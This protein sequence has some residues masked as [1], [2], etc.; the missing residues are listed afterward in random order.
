MGAPVPVPL[1]VVVENSG[2]V[3]GELAQ[4]LTQLQTTGVAAL[5]GAK[6]L[7]PSSSSYFLVLSQPLKS[8]KKGPVTQYNGSHLISYRLI[9][10][11]VYS[12]TN[13]KSKTISYAFPYILLRFTIRIM[14]YPA[15]YRRKIEQFWCSPAYFFQSSTYPGF[16][17]VVTQ[18]AHK[19]IMEH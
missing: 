6:S 3:S 4:L 19:K 7:K 14:S 13:L 18:Q 12:P 5:T 9:E 15:Y 2:V 10:Y 16:T 11:P 17:G 1:C 8:P